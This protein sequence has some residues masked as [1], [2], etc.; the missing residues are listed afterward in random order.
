M[1]LANKIVSRIMEIMP[2]KFLNPELPKMSVEEMST[3]L[4]EFFV[5]TMQDASSLD[6][7]RATTVVYYC[8]MTYH[9]GFKFI[10]ILN[11]NGE[12]GTG[13][14]TGILYLMSQWAKDALFFSVE[15]DSRVSVRNKLANRRT[16]LVDEADHTND[17]ASAEGWYKKRSEVINQNAEYSVQQ[18]GSERNYNVRGIFNHFGFTVL[19]TQE[20]LITGQMERRTLS[21]TVYKDNTR[22][23]SIYP[24]QLNTDLLKMVSDRVDWNSPMSSN[25]AW[26][27]W[28]P[29]YRIGAY[30]GNTEYCAWIEEQVV[31]KLEDDSLSGVFEPKGVIF[32][33]IAKHYSETVSNLSGIYRLAITEIVHKTRQRGYHYNEKQVV[34]FIKE[35]GLT[36]K[37]P[38]NAA[39][40]YVDHMDE[41][42]AVAKKIGAKLD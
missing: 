13:K 35:M 42:K 40:V 11:L 16:V 21:I 3:E 30:L 31:T 39:H 1:V 22:T 7:H 8:I 12:S 28:A 17:Q 26:D 18:T 25:T 37:Y 24:A 14:S 15:E 27:V 4:N 38:Q 41:L 36:I 33:E 29:F 10:P 32:S 2:L 34:G 23:Y 19:H 20:P 6:K 5:G 9:D